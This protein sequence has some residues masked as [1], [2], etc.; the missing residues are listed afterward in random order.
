MGEAIESRAEGAVAGRVAGLAARVDGD[1]TLRRR[2]RVLNATCQ[3]SVGGEHFL[4]RIADGRVIE[5]RGGPF[6]TPSADF[7]IIADAAIW[8]RLLAP[9]P[10]PGD[11]DILAFVKR[12]ELRLV[13]DLHPF[14]SHLLYWK[15][16]LA[17]LRETAR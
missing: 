8:H 13:G 10:P 6:A 5:T 17:H 2:G 11:H 4:L 14:M 3:L 7:A 9:E 1:A 15:V 12:G 16:L